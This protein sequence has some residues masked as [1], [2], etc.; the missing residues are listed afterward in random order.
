MVFQLHLIN[1]FLAELHV[2]IGAFCL[3]PKNC[4]APSYV[5]TASQSVR[6]KGSDQT[7]HIGSSSFTSKLPTSPLVNLSSSHSCG[8][9][10]YQTQTLYL[11]L[12]LVSKP[13]QSI[14][15]DAIM[16][17]GRTKSLRRRIY[18]VECST[19]AQVGRD[20]NVWGAR[21]AIR[22]TYLYGSGQRPSFM[23]ERFVCAPAGVRTRR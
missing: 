16:F 1:L 17:R 8:R 14:S 12:D 9:S 22:D 13:V 18:F 5:M 11:V 10:A 3:T 21:E 23:I 7:S 19:I 20:V 15:I 2:L 4:P 6:R